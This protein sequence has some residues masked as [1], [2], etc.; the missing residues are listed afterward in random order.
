MLVLSR[1]VGERVFI[2]DAIRIV[3]V[4]INRHNVRL[5]IE[6]P[7]VKVDREEIALLKTR[8]ARQAGANTR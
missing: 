8:K 4:R 5:G 7:G 6:A 2:G 3:V 1:Q